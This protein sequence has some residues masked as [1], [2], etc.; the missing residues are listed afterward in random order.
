VENDENKIAQL[1]N[2]VRVLKNEVQA[3]LLDL[4]ESCL[5]AENPF[6]TP[7]SPVT[8][9]QQIIVDRPLQAT[10]P[11]APVGGRPADLPVE[12]QGVERKQEVSEATD[13][14]TF[15]L[16]PTHRYEAKKNGQPERDSGYL[17]PPAPMVNHPPAPAIDLLL[18]VGL[19]RW[20]VKS[21]SKVGRARTETILDISS[22]MGYL[23]IEL[24]QIMVK[25]VKIDKNGQQDAVVTR[26]YLRSLVKLTSLLGKDNKTE[27]ALLSILSGEDDHR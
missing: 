9:A 10:A 22:L 26:E 13:S 17:V 2:E 6:N 8:T 7:V 20:A 1:E 3:V 19:A 14:A 12:N 23:P 25:L 27:T 18:I 16:Q 21:A 24:K 11:T 15:P 4:R 5:D